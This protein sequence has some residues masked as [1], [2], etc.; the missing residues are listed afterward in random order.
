[1][2]ERWLTGQHRSLTVAARCAGIGAH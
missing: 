2:R 1:V